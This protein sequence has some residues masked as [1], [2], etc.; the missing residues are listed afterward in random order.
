MQSGILSAMG[1]GSANYDAPAAQLTAASAASVAATLQ[2][3]ATP[4]R[5]LI[6]AALRRE[7]CTPSRLA[8]QLGMEQSAVSHQ[9]RLL[10]NLG[11]VAATRQGKNMVYALFDN[12][13][14]QLLDQ[15]VYHSEHLRLGLRDSP[16]QRPEEPA[17]TASIATR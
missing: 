12:H 1:H 11:L 14:A 16:A 13:V 8:E 2:A 15:A 9:L 17:A 4:S 10:R 5:L 6:L 3:L 7:P